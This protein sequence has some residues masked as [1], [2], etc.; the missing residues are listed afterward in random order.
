MTWVSW[1]VDTDVVEHIFAGSKSEV[2]VSEGSHSRGLMRRGRYRTI[3]NNLG[4]F[5]ACPGLTG[6]G[7]LDENRSR[8]WIIEKYNSSIKVLAGGP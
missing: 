6:P 1:R 4:V 7:S 5:V 2:I 3:A 8:L